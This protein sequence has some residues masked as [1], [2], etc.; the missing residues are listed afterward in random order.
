MAEAVDRAKRR[1]QVV[2][3]RVAERLKLRV[4]SPELLRALLHAMLE[5]LR[6]AA[7]LVLNRSPFLVELH[8]LQREREVGR[9]PVEQ[10]D[11]FLVE[12]PWL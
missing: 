10:L 5:L 6:Q 8:R 7:Q 4:R 2:R 12:E 9:Q 1:A 11:L 3:D